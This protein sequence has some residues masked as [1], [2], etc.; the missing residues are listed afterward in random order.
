MLRQKAALDQHVE[1]SFDN[2]VNVAKQQRLRAACSPRKPCSG[3]H[4][5]PEEQALK[6]K[7]EAFVKH[8][9]PLRHLLWNPETFAPQPQQRLVRTHFPLREISVPTERTRLRHLSLTDVFNHLNQRARDLLKE[10]LN[11]ALAQAKD[12][13]FK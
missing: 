11:K 5:K 3:R 4:S 1:K 8:S 12:P 6:K 7:A 2:W 10:D 9:K 13:T